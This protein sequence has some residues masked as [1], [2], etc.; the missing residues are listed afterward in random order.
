MNHLKIFEDYNN[1]DTDRCVKCNWCEW[2]GRES[3]LDEE[4]C[5]VCNNSDYIMDV[6]F[7]DDFYDYIENNKPVP[8]INRNDYNNIEDYYKDLYPEYFTY[9]KYN[10]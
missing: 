9:K 7:D 3:E 8:N 6:Y 5:P 1:D 4:Q 2:F 10:L